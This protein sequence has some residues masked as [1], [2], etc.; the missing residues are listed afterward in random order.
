MVR[1]K[2]VPKKKTTVRKAVKKTNQKP[3]VKA[4]APAEKEDISPKVAKEDTEAMESQLDDMGDESISSNTGTPRPGHGG[5]DPSANLSLAKKPV[6][7]SQKDAGEAEAKVAEKE[8]DLSIRAK[9]LEESEEKMKNLAKVLE[10][11]KK[12]LEAKEKELDVAEAVLEKK[13]VTDNSDKAAETVPVLNA[14]AVDPIKN[15]LSFFERN[16]SGDLVFSNRTHYELVFSDL[17]FPSPG[18][19]FDP[20]IFKPYQQRDL[21]VEGFTSEQVISSKNLRNFIAAGKMK[22]GPLTEKDKLSED[23]KFA[24]VRNLGQD[25]TTI[26]IKFTGHYFDL[27][28]KFCAKEKLRFTKAED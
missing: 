15:D 23:T 1:K 10:D 8:K 21:E 16:S 24:A 14:G 17:G 28:T 22:H 5:A 12:L 3:A 2:P 27:Y 20:L 6:P 25:V 13:A 9:E 11:R 26:G 4:K 18:H 7:E 19:K